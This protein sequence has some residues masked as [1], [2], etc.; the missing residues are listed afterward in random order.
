MVSITANGTQQL[1]ENNNVN[2]WSNNSWS[3]NSLVLNIAEP[4]ETIMK[5]E[6][7]N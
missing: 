5:D 2:F 3:K 4:I 6:V 1:I 7:E